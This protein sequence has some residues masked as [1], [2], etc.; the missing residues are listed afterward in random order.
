MSASLHFP[1][2]LRIQLVDSVTGHGVPGLAA[3]VTAFAPRKNDYRLGKISD[4][5]GYLVITRKEMENSVRSDQNLFPMDYASSLN[6]CAPLIELRVCSVDEIQNAVKAMQMFQ[7]LGSTDPV[8]LEGFKKSRNGRYAAR[9]ERID[10]S[11]PTDEV[12]VV[13][14]IQSREGGETS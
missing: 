7:P 13:V 6:E 11:R 2:S 12:T 3:I 9:S 10:C 5:A 8:L 1:R 4:D 14:R